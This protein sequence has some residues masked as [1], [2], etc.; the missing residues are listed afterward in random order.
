MANTYGKVSG[1]FQEIQ[2]AY[3]KVSGTW[4]EVDEIYAKDSGTW[5]LVFSAFEATSYV[6]LSSG[7]GTFAVPQGANAIHIQAAVGGGGGA[8]GGADY[9]KAGG[10]SAGAGGGSGAYISDKVFTVVESETISYSIGSG[11][12][13][14]N[15]TANFKQPR[16][17][18]AGTNTTLSGSTTGSLFTLGAGG[19]SS[20]TGGGVQGPL[21]TNTAGTAGSATI[22]GTA[23]TS[24]NF[25]DSD[26]TT[27]SV[28][29]LTGG[30]VGT[31]NQSGNGATGGISGSNNCGGDNCQ[32]GGSNGGASYAGN[33]SG[34][35]GSPIGGGAGAAGT[36]GSG[37]GG[38]GAQYSGGST[39]GGAGCNGEIKYRFLKVN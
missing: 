6:T 15:Q 8:A 38:G 23:V 29:T 37:G 32:I 1:T 10:E 30:P 16:I 9:D 21:R 28:T 17:A 25:R 36:R 39:D 5:E 4:E 18:S 11:G 19:G 14:G 27:K 2:N 24:G 22:S 33:I 7:S 20:G 3:G 13:A 12:A 34:G 31:F 26:G 35:A